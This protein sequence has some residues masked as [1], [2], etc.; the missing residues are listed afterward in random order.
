[1][2]PLHGERRQP[3]GRS[4]A[5]R[6]P[7]SWPATCFTVDTVWLGR[8]EV[9]CFIELD[10]R[11]VHLAGITA[12]PDGAWVT[13]PAHNLLLALKERNR[14]RRFVLGDRDARFSRPFADLFR[15]EGAEILLAPV[16]APS[17]NA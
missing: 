15:S 16:Q 3:G 7:G 4:C 12:N 11:R 8:L 5:D 14:Q 9:L 13:Q 2:I 6:P 1:V 17:A 10:T